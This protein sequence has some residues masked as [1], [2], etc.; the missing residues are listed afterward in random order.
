LL[1]N[2]GIELNNQ[3]AMDILLLAGAK[4]SPDS[5]IVSLTDKISRTAVE[6]SPIFFSLQ[7]QILNQQ[8]FD[9][10]PSPPPP[11]PNTSIYAKLS[12]GQITNLLSVSC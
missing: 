7:S 8:I 6:K 5:N 11:F 3:E 12:L 4:S 10:L 2:P 9:Y 1:E